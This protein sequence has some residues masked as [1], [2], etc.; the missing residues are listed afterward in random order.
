[1]KDKRLVS[2]VIPTFNSSKFF[3]TCLR[4]VREQT[5][6]NVEIIVVDNYSTDKTKEIAEKR[7]KVVLHK[8]LRSDARNIGV[9]SARGEFIFFIDSDMELT[10]NVITECVAKV[11][12]G[13]DAIIVPE[14][15]VG[16]SFWAR[17]KALEKACYIGDDWIEAARFLKKNVFE[18]IGGYDARLVFGEDWDLHQKIKGAGF[19]IGRMNALIRHHEGQL[20]LRDIILKKHYYGKTWAIYRMKHPKAAKQQLTLVRPAFVKNWRELAKDPGHTLGMI[21]MKTCEFVASWLGTFDF[22]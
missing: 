5:Y 2:V 3:E 15:S 19:R 9:A 18:T 17:C 21:F 13:F 7:G 8:G 1:M 6:K 20:S 11:E 4:S 10:P 16:E 12:N 14:V 22:Q